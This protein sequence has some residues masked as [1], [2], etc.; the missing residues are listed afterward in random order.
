MVADYRHTSTGRGEPAVKRLLCGDT[1]PLRSNVAVAQELDCILAYLDVP[2][3]SSCSN[4][5][6]D[7]RGVAIESTP[8]N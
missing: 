3:A 4:Q 2:P 5:A 7:K 6:Y 1:L 8:D